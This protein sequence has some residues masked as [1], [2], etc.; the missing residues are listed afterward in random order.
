MPIEAPPAGARRVHRRAAVQRRP[1]GAA[2][3]VEPAEA[4]RYEWPEMEPSIVLENVSKNYGEGSAA[5]A[6]VREVTLRIDEGEF[7]SIIGPSGCGKSTLLNLMAGID[8]PNSG[9]VFLHGRDLSAMSDDDRSDMRLESVGFIFQSF[10]LFPTFTAEENVSWPLGFL[11]RPAGEARRRAAE[12]LDL[13]GLSGAIRKR[14]PTEM[15]GGEQQRVAIAR[16][17]TAEPRLLLADEPTGNLDS[18]NGHL[19]MDLIRGLNRSHG[20]TVVLVTHSA[21]AAEYSNRRI[22]LR[23]GRIVSGNGRPSTDD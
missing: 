2:A 10:N 16:A 15:S 8:T 12:V 20:I 4:L 21:F 1:A 11:G 18:A 7:V 3:R 22:E 9:R 5:V 13:V 17:L 14:R 19:I 6:A 23:D